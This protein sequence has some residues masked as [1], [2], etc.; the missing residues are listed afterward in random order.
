MMN[1]SK[2]ERGSERGIQKGYHSSHCFD[3]IWDPEAYWKVEWEGDSYTPGTAKA[4]PGCWYISLYKVAR[5]HP[6]G[7][8]G[9]GVGRCW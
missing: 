7:D 2:F 9:D 4:P 6:E 1:Q 8:V 3:S 5:Q